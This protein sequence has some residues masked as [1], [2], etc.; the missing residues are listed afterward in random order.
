MLVLTF[1]DWTKNNQTIEPFEYILQLVFDI[2]PWVHKV[3][4][5]LF[6]KMLQHNRFLQNKSFF[7]NLGYFFDGSFSCGSCQNVDLYLSTLF[8]W[9][10][11]L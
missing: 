4:I 8:H 1:R 5:L 6:T 7:P 2:A 3:F 9:T 10:S 11:F